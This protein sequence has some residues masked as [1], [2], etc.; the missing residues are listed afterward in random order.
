MS[1]WNST[2]YRHIGNKKDQKLLFL[3]HSFN[4]ATIGPWNCAILLTN[5][6][7]SVISHQDWETGMYTCH[8][9]L[10]SQQSDMISPQHLSSDYVPFIFW[11]SFWPKRTK[12]QVRQLN[13]LGTFK[14]D[15]TWMSNNSI[16]IS[17]RIVAVLLTLSKNADAAEQC[18]SWLPICSLYFDS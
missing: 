10:K 14:T 17:S 3:I 11:H 6:C 15:L 2:L 9:W 16:E 8:I 18:W 1:T 4:I 7:I 5:N 13:L 12:P